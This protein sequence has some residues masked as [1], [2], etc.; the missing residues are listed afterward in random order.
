MV[1]SSTNYWIWFLESDTSVL[2]D[3][4]ESKNPILKVPKSETNAKAATMTL[5]SPDTFEGA[6]IS[7]ASK[8][9]IVY[10]S[11]LDEDNEEVEL[12]EAASI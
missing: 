2:V 11:F 7:P 1:I 5:I 3:D 6:S 9:P 12:S 4:V 8:T 10:V